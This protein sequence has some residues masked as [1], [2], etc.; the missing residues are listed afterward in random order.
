MPR[1]SDVVII[2]AGIIGLSTA[3]TLLR[4]GWRV[5]VV[6]DRPLELSTSYIA[7][8][9]WFPTHVGPRERVLSWGRRAYSVFERQ[10]R[11]G[12]PGVTMIRSV[13][14]CRKP[15][16]D[17]WWSSAVRGIEPAGKEDLP[18][19]Y[20]SG[21]RFI[22]P[23]VE[24]PLY[25]PWALNQVA[26]LG[27]QFE[28]RHFESILEADAQ[29]VVNCSGLGARSLIGDYSVSPV[30][31][32]IVR[33]SNPGLTVSIRDEDHPD[34]RA[35]VHPR[36]RDCILGGTLEEGSW[37]E[38]VDPS[39]SEAIIKRCAD[40]APQLSN[41]R[42][43]EHVVGLRPGRPCVRLEREEVAKDRLVVH[44]YGH[45][46]AGITLSWGCAEEVVSM[47]G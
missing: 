10:A 40:L 22:A 38:Q 19:G 15:D 43:L 36:S 23:L 16:I 26:N 35:Y 21:F 12:V 9:V 42:V 25:L 41:A 11:S 32:Q 17:L 3:V 46:G 13:M 37:D 33:V 6:S 24:M 14:L 47:L 30:R 8:A 18:S 20:D 29:L 1:R 31:G 45:G 39:S 34:G 28:N 5:T 7:A 2:G 44:N 4:A 27:G